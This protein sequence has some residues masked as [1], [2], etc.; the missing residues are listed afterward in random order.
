[1]ERLDLKD[2]EKHHILRERPSLMRLFSKVLLKSNSFQI[3]NDLPHL[4]NQMEQVNV[5]P[6]HLH[7]YQGVC[8]FDVG[9]TLP[10]TYLSMLGFPLIL[11]LM[12][13]GAFPM[14]AMGQVHLRNSISVHKS[15]SLGMAFSLKAAIV[16]SEITDKGVEWSVE[17]KA[18][19]D[20]EVV[21]SSLSTMLHRCKTGIPRWVRP[22]SSADGKA[23][24]WRV[25]SATGRDYASVSGDYN[26]IHLSNISAKMFGFSQA[27]VH[28]MWSK[29]R[30]LAAMSDQLPKDKFRVEVEFQKPLFIPSNVKFYS[31]N[32][33]GNTTFQL[34]NE[35]GQHVHLDGLITKDLLNV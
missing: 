28:G 35:S 34:F 30:C 24:V 15:I 27:I 18:L 9:S 13:R 17:T 21:W 25:K 7:S 5:D 4:S 26:P 23:Q 33:G 29:A 6:E 3:G 10:A 1:M 16:G 22:K 8:G 32:E 14:K 31:Q 11:E 12:T 19:V 2:I 20:Q